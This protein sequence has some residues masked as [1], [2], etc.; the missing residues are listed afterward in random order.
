M[1]SSDTADQQP[2]S[3]FISG[4]ASGLGRALT[5]ILVARGHRVSGIVDS[6]DS[7]K[8]LREAGGLPVYANPRRAGE[9]RSAMQVAKSEVVVHLATQRPNG[10]PLRSSDGGWDDTALADTILAETA[11]LLEA[12]KAAGI[13]FFVHTSYAYLYGATGG[14]SADESARVSSANIPAL[15]AALKAE[16][17][18]L[19]GSIPACVL[20]A[21][22]VYGPDVESTTELRDNLYKGSALLPSGKT[23]P[24]SWVYQDDLA[25]AAA[26]AAE[27]Q[28]AG[29][30][31][32]V[33][34]NQPVSL[35]QFISQ[36]STVFGLVNAP[37]R[38]RAFGESRMTGK[39]W[40]ALVGQSTQVSSSKAQ[41]K[42]GWKLKAPSIREG[43]E[44]TLLAWRAADYHAQSSPSA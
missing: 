28:P 31:F 32:N 1:Q 3:V 44:Q 20:R 25:L 18:A 12:S 23:A 35:E 38:M 22:M 37:G 41:E 10:I 26:L 15:D 17:L 4:A 14:H 36:F 29:E 42:L 39:N 24:A 30:I 19:Q 33:A 6:A 11:A 5:R 16:Q 2:L 13:K 40:R 7:A 27:L 8:Q 21:G 34:D 43:I 9:I